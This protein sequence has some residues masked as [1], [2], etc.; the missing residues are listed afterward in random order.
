MDEEIT[1][2]IDSVSISDRSMLYP[3]HRVKMIYY[4]CGANVVELS[5]F[6]LLTMEVIFYP[7]E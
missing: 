3:V 6:N 7:A 2:E 1:A 4:S 5:N